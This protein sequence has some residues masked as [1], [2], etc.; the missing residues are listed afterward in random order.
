MA[1]LSDLPRP[2]S[3]VAYEPSELI[4]LFQTDLYDLINREP[5]LGMRLIRS[6]SRITGERL[7]HTYEELMHLRGTLAPDE[8]DQT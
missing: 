8:G 4:V 3:A 1:L 7:V 6:L 2:A 5:E